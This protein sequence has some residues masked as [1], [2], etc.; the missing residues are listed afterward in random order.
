MALPDIISASEYRK[1][2]FQHS[3]FLLSRAIDSFKLQYYNLAV[4]FAITAIEEITNNLYSWTEKFENFD[5]TNFLDEFIPLTQ[6]ILKED[7]KFT[8]EIGSKLTKIFEKYFK[9]DQPKLKLSLKDLSSQFRMKEHKS[10]Q[11]KTLTA[12]IHSLSI[13]PEAYR[14]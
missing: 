13:N 5:I 14:N 9:E 6:G 4:F 10:H 7:I 12:L 1:I 3:Y 8:E 2:V 11:K